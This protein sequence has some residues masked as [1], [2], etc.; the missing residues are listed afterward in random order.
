MSN[1]ED[2]EN[3]GFNVTITDYWGRA[4]SYQLVNATDGGPSYTFSSIADQD[5]FTSGS[6]PL[7][8]IVTDGRAPG[9]L[10]VTGNA[11][12]YTFSPWELGSEDPT[13]FGFVPLEYVGTNF[14]SGSPSTDQCVT[15]FD[16]VGLVMGTSSSLF[17][18]LMTTVNRANTTGL[19]SNALQEALAH[20]LTDVGSSGDDIADWPNPFYGYNNDTN[21]NAQSIQLTLVDGGEDNQNIPLHPLIQPNRHVD[22]IFAVDS[23]ADTNGSYPTSGSAQNWPAG[24]SLV[25]TYERSLS[26][27][28]NGTCEY[29]HSS[30]RLFANRS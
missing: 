7:P 19:F 18:S 8:F 22:V 17:N 20:V 12:V 29:R 27:I 30:E 13:V 4:L 6:V 25:A 23:S 3:T 5:F 28:Q 14:T 1:V 21:P 2:K 11:T 16:N 15:G 9:Q 26:P 24:I 10:L